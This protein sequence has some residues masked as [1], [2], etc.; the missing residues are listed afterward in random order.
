MSLHCKILESCIGRVSLIL[1]EISYVRRNGC[2]SL[3]NWSLIITEV[4]AKSSSVGKG[5]HATHVCWNLARR[6]LKWIWILQCLNHILKLQIV[7][8]LSQKVV[9]L[10]LL[11]HIVLLKIWRTWLLVIRHL[12]RDKLLYIGRGTSL[13]IIFSLW[14]TMLLL[15]DVPWTNTTDLSVQILT[16][17]SHSEVSREIMILQWIWRWF[18]TELSLL[19]CQGSHVA[20]DVEKVTGNRLPLVD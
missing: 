14:I 10:H 17:R 4:T 6:I 20:L 18:T 16:W 3:R 12:H 19:V 1:V 2:L 7:L 11:V 9:V 8:F 15:Y 13:L 5:T